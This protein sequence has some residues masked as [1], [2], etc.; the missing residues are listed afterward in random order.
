MKWQ[1]SLLVLLLMSSIFVACSDNGN[2]DPTPSSQ[3][4]NTNTATTIAPSTETLKSDAKEKR[5]DVAAKRLKDK[6]QMMTETQF[7]GENTDKY[8]LKQ[9]FK[10]DKNGNQLELSEYTSTGSLNSTIKS[11]YDSSGK[12][13]GEETTLATGEVAIR[14]VI[15]TDEKG[16]KV[17]EDIKQ[18]NQKNT[19][20]NTRY[21]YKYDE[22][23][24]VIERL[25]VRQNGS[26]FLKYTFTYDANG[27][28]TEW[29][30]L[31]NKDEIMGKFVF[32][33]DN[34]NNII[35]ETRYNRDGSVKDAFTYSYEFDSKGNWTRQKRIKN[36]SV[37]EVRKREYK[38]Y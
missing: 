37:V 20:A 25:G 18:L 1:R 30:Q 22:K 10:Y 33:Y 2:D 3:A 12:I 31:S 23:A 8:N 7:P 21:T 17:E 36:G 13:A 28:M 14:S 11:L 16:N 19:L 26:F 32:K 15:K 9:V 24:H 6:V 4:A 29:L 34:K 38:Y 5:S 35:E 27:N